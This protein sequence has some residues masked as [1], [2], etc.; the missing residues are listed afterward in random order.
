[1]GGFLLINGG[2]HIY[3]PAW[4]R[5]R[6]APLWHARIGVFEMSFVELEA[7]IKDI[8]AQMDARNP[9][10]GTYKGENMKCSK[11]GKTRCVFCGWYYYECTYPKNE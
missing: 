10:Q 7:K 6:D 8:R 4:N 5:K 1:M 11:S 9:P 2:K 3:V